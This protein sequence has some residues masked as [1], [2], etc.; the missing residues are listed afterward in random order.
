M[1][2]QIFTRI[3]IGVVAAVLFLLLAAATLTVQAAPSGQAGLDPLARLGKAIFFDTRL[4]VPPGQSCATCHDPQAGFADPDADLPVSQGAIKT[5]F[6]NRNA[7][8]VTY[9]MYSPALYFDSTPGPG[10]MEGQYKGGL[11]WDSRVDTLEEQAKQPFLNH[12]EMNNPNPARVVLMARISRYAGLF[13]KACSPAAR[14]SISASYDCIARALAAYMRSSEVNPFTSK[15]DYWK[16]GQAEFTEAELNGYTLFTGEAKCK[17]C[18]TEGYFTNFGHQN[19][20]APKNPDLPYYNLPKRLN[21]DGKNYIDLGLGDVLRQAGLSEEEAAKQDGKFKIP[22]LR[23]V[24]L[25]PPYE[26]N[27]VFQTLRE[28]VM[29]NNT[30]DVEGASWP[31]PEVAENVHRHMPPMPNTFGQL[32]LTDQ[33][34]DDIVAFLETLSDGYQ[35]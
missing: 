32:G 35:P 7:P 20:G 6:G 21:P 12:L 33:E 27:G 5:R 16:A 28:V 10:V 4:S 17:N 19:V 2:S 34:V 1:R 23:N 18:H 26:H 14:K 30:R 13:N 25:T 15:Y 9:A 8:S 22:S 31:A 24:A 3:T 29:F 11:F